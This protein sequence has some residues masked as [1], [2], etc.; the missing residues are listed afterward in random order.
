MK[1]L[2]LNLF[3]II[4]SIIIVNYALSSYLDYFWEE[5]YP[6]LPTEQKIEADLY[7]NR[8]NKE[9]IFDIWNEITGG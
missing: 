6:T 2:P 1:N 4:T 8:T 7:K 3:S 5:V 9:M